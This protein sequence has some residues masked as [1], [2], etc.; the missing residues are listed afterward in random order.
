MG[1]IAASGVGRARPAL[2][3]WKSGGEWSSPGKEWRER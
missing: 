1:G 3:G 2:Q